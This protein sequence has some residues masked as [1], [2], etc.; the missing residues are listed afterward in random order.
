MLTSGPALRFRVGR[1][2]VTINVTFLLVTTL[3]GWVSA[4]VGRARL[5][6]DRLEFVV[7]WLLIVVVSVLVHEWGHVLALR[8][9]GRDS[10]VA[11]SAFGGLTTSE[12]QRPLAPGPSVVVSVAGPAAGIAFGLLTAALLPDHPTGLVHVIAYQLWFVN[13]W[14]SVFNLLP[15]VPLD[16]GHVALAAFESA[17][18]V[19]GGAVAAMGGASLAIVGAGVGLFD[20]EHLGWA[21]VVTALMIAT[22]ANRIPLTEAQRRTVAAADAHEMMLTGELER[23]SDELLRLMAARPAPVVSTEAYTT[24]AWALLHQG[25]FDELS[26]L[27]LQRLHPNH[28]GLVGSALAWYRGDFATCAAVLPRELALSPVDPPA[29]Y[30]KVTFGRL[31]EIDELQSWIAALPPEMADVARGRLWASLGAASRA[32]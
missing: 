18:R 14:W 22:T 16:G 20:G 9:Y 5:G 27:D 6:V 3:V 24:L 7:A 32:A 31:G 28:R 8:R 12:D 17:A 10:S 11:L 26:H 21:F 25:R 4:S 23:G 15:I 13:I 30:F 19:P 1:V 29:T 2:P